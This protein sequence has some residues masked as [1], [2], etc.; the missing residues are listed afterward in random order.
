MISDHSLL[1]A[2]GKPR[3]A[4]PCLSGCR[5]ALRPVGLR[6]DHFGPRAWRA[7]LPAFARRF[8][9]VECGLRLAFIMGAC[10]FDARRP[11]RRAMVSVACQGGASGQYCSHRGFGEISV[12]RCGYQTSAKLDCAATEGKSKTANCQASFDLKRFLG[13][14]SAADEVSLSIVRPT[15]S[16]RRGTRRDTVFYI[17]QGRVKRQR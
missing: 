14:W 17:Q 13:Q 3:R 6:E 9:V 4:S 11:F 8:L 2:T 5:R 12:K 16:S 1:P 10:A 15:A 7:A